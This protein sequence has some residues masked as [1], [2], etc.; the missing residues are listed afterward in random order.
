MVLNGGKLGVAA[1]ETIG[2]LFFGGV[3]QAT[4]TYGSTS[5]A[6]TFKDNTRFSGTGI[7][8]VTGVV[9]AGPYALWSAVISNPAD[10]DRTDDPDG[11]GLTNLQEYLF[12]T[13]PIAGNGATVQTQ[14]SPSGLVVRWCQRSATGAYVLQEGTTLADPWAVSAVV[15]V[16]AAD[17]SGLYSADYVRKEAVIPINSVRKFVRVQATE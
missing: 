15:P 7:V 10:R 2:T 12:G 8:T 9:A 6:A 3:Q 1:D 14:S 4:G 13:S 16:N 11:D 5:S 17:Q